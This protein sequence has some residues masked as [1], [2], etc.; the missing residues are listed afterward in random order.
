MNLDYNIILIIII[1][2]IFL[3]FFFNLD[4]L[5]ILISFNLDLFNGFV[6]K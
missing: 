5:G 6:I 3:I 2:L 4:F 1:I